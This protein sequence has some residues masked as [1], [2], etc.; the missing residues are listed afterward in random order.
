MHNYNP[1][2]FGSGDDR[3]ELSKNKVRDKPYLKK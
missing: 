2:Y 1:N 3:M